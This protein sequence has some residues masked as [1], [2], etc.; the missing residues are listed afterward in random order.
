MYYNLFIKGIIKIN[1]YLLLFKSNKIASKGKDEL[2]FYNIVLNKEIDNNIKNEYSFLFSPN[3]LIIFPPQDKIVNHEYKNYLILC[4]CKK[5]LK[6]QKNGILV[7][8]IENNDFD[9]NKINKKYYFYN[10]YNFE[11]Y[12]FCPI[13]ILINSL[14][15]ILDKAKS[16]IYK[17]SGYFL[18]GGFDKNKNKGMIKLFKIN[19]GKEY[20]E[21]RI[22]YIENIIFNDNNFKGFKGPISC[23]TQSSIDGKLLISCWDGNIYLFDKPNIEYYL[24]Y[25]KLIN[26]NMSFKKF[27][28][29][30]IK[31]Y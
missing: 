3:G 26:K 14:D 7:V 9:L 25:D 27:F 16:V 10:T 13:L 11:V 24:E 4:A 5:Y 12:C 19:Y 17:D 31:F 21:T 30:K 1:E 15:I 18:V 23:I 22:E 2:L 28:K 20:Y 6:N 8:N 29:K